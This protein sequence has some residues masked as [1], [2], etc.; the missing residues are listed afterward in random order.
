MLSGVGDKL[1]LEQLGIQPRLD[2]PDVGQNLQDHPI[3]ASYWNVASTSTF[4]DILRDPTL[5]SLTLSQWEANRTGR[6]VDSPVVGI[7][8]M[9]LPENSAALKG[10]EDPAAG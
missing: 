8:F 7:G 4:D 3:L 2:I 6:F 5:S 1:V 10:I 9:R